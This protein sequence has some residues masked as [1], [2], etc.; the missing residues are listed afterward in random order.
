M[1]IKKFL[2]LTFA[3]SICLLS[4]CNQ[5][6]DP[7]VNVDCSIINSSYSINIKPIIDANCVSS[8]CHSTNSTNGDFTIYN[9]LKAKADNGSLSGRVVQQKTMPPTQPLSLD[10]L[11]KMKCWIDS[12]ALNN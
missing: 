1:Y 5:D 3:I 12:G 4:G 11:K 10:N 8:G 2:P 7:L 6:D 9:G